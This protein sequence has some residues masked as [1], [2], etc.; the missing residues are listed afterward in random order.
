MITKKITE[1]QQFAESKGNVLQVQN[2]EVGQTSIDTMKG[3]IVTTLLDN[4]GVVLNLV[5]MKEAVNTYAD[6]PTSNVN[7]NDAYQVTADGLV[8]VYTSNGFQLDGDGFNILPEPTGIVEQGNTN[9]VSGG[10]VSKHLTAVG[11]GNK[12]NNIYLNAVVLDNYLYRTSV[13]SI[14]VMHPILPNIDYVFKKDGGSTDRYVT[15]SQR[16][17]ITSTAKNEFVVKTGTVLNGKRIRFDDNEKY[18]LWTIDNNSLNPIVDIFNETILLL[19]EVG[20]KDIAN[21]LENNNFIVSNLYKGDTVNAVVLDTFRYRLSDVATTIIEPILDNKFYYFSKTGGDR[22]RYLFLSDYP[23]LT[24]ST[25]VKYVIG[26]GSSLNNKRI[27]PP[28]GTKYIMWTVSSILEDV[29]INIQAEVDLKIKELDALSLNSLPLINDIYKCLDQVNNGSLSTTQYT[30]IIDI[31]NNLMINYPT[32]ITREVIGQSVGGLDIFMFRIGA[33][34]VN[35]PSNNRFKKRKIFIDASIHG[36]EEM[37]GF[38]T[39]KFF[40]DIFTRR[41][42]VND[43]ILFNLEFI[44]VPVANPDGYNLHQRNN[45][46]NVDLNRDFF[47]QT[48]PETIALISQINSNDFDYYLSVHNIASPP[49]MFYVRTPENSL[50][51]YN[52]FMDIREH[53]ISRYDLS[54]TTEIGTLTTTTNEGTA[55]DYLTNIGKKSITLESPWKQAFDTVKY[56]KITT[57]TAIEMVGN[58]VINIAKML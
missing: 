7:I 9:A 11:G 8:Y 12:F 10:E 28:L 33:D 22:D 36:H 58:T 47:N 50:L 31:Y 20:K 57:E 32:L 51:G 41:N 35:I 54:Q 40:E 1:V 30:H 2:S 21:Y 37:A 46:N 29:D 48:Q 23:E 24:T 26:Q 6:L 55:T 44:V 4:N 52:F 3:E 39:A 16:P 25:S 49:S 14:S 27:K 56:G 19:D 38:S 34:V 17:N 43:W 15:L 53:W 45:A 13:T 18:I 42:D 5:N